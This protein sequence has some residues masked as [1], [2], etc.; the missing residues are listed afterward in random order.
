MCVTKNVMVQQTLGWFGAYRK[1]ISV[2]WL[3]RD[4]WHGGRADN[5]KRQ[6]KKQKKKKNNT[7][8]FNCK[9]FESW[10]IYDWWRQPTKFAIAAI[11]NFVSTSNFI[12]IHSQSIYKLSMIRFMHKVH[13]DVVF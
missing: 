2:P 13:F 10:E 7:K 12:S 8:Y 4:Y 5:S 3:G 6:K 1:T 9:A 11:L